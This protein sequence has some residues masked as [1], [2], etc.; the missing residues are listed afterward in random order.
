M[1]QRRV[2]FLDFDG[3]LADHGVVPAAHVEVLARIRAAGH[4]VLLST[5]R[6]A[7]IVEDAVLELLDGAVCSAGA[8]VTVDGELLR[9][10]L[11]P[12]E[13]AR[14]AAEVLLDL[15]APFVLE[16]PEAI[17]CP[18]PMA[19]WLRARAREAVPGPAGSVGGGSWALARAA[20]VP[21]DL[22]ACSFAKISLWQ[23]PIPV[24][25]VAARIG[26]QVGALPNSM[27]RGDGSSGELHLRSIDKADGLRQVAEHL[28]L[29][30]ADTIAVG[31]GMNDLGML[32]AAGTAVAIQGAPAVVA[33]AADLVVPGPAEGGLVLA[34]ERLGLV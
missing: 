12:A 2:V 28:G 9:D 11:F 30:I 4:T 15:G 21:E 17:Y 22:T 13:L 31:D 27:S 1:S 25:E 20:V 3:T 29:T 10:D 32:R 16:A 34:A 23:S 7:S 6:P 24:D 14:H 19:D 5:G 33:E 8:H 26:D 18:Q